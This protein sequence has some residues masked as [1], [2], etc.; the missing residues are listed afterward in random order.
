MILLS[1]LCITRLFPLPPN[2]S[3]Q[4]QR[5]KDHWADLTRPPVRQLVC[6]DRGKRTAGAGRFRFLRECDYNTTFT[7]SRAPPFLMWND[8]GH[9]AATNPVWPKEG[10]AAKRRQAAPVTFH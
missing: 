9:A 8:S 10:S 7:R 1:Y 4:S 3:D 5:S 6:V 2:D